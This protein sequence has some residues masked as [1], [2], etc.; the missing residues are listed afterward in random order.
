MWTLLSL[1]RPGP[2]DWIWQQSARQQG[3]ECK[4]GPRSTN[5]AHTVADSSFVPI[6][7]LKQPRDVGM[8]AVIYKDWK[9]W[10]RSQHLFLT[11]FLFYCFC[12]ISHLFPMVHLL[13]LLWFITPLSLCRILLP[14]SSDVQ[15]QPDDHVLLH[16]R[17]RGHHAHQRHGT[18]N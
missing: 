11:T 15:F 9:V 4:P 16:Q 3:C 5:P 13:N 7:Q 2:D 12:N 8:I 14:G 18:E 17:G 1:G 10:W 6:Y